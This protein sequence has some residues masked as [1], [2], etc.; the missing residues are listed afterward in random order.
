[1]ASSDVSE[2]FLSSQSHKPLESES[3]QNHLKFFR[4]RVTRTVESLRV[5]GLQA[6][7]NVESPEMI[8]I[9]FAGWISGRI[10]SLQPDTDIRKL[11]SNGNRISDTI[12]SIFR[13]I[14]LLGEVARC[15]IIHLLS[16][17]RSIFSAFCA[18]PPSLS[19][20]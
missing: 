18:M 2:S 17:F 12:L 8:T 16:S 20:V 4:V 6:R 14:R 13:G 3:S 9:R 19:V 15:T 10:V 7:V 1:M 11:V 5:I